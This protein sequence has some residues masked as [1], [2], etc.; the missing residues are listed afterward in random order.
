MCQIRGRIL[1]RAAVGFGYSTVFQIS[2]DFAIAYP[3]IGS[4]YT[5]YYILTGAETACFLG[6]GKTEVPRGNLP[7]LKPTSN[8]TNMWHDPEGWK[9]SYTVANCFTDLMCFTMKT[10]FLQVSRLFRHGNRITFIRDLELRLA[11]VMAMKGLC[12]CTCIFDVH[13]Y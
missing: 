1:T 8:S 3:A 6:E 4:S 9:L 13:S 7:Q 5:L 10:F 2:N 12:S 11:D